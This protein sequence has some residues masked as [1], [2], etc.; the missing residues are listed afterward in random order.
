VSEKILKATEEKE[1]IIREIKV[2]RIHGIQSLRF[3]K[4]RIEKSIFRR[5]RL[6]LSLSLISAIP[7]KSFVIFITDLSTN[8]GELIT[9]IQKLRDAKALIISPNPI[10]FSELKPEREEILKLYRKYVEREEMIRKMNRIVPTIDVGPRDLLS[11]IGGSSM[12]SSV[13]SVIIA[14][15]LGL[16]AP[17][18]APVV[19]RRCLL[20][21]DLLRS[22]GLRILN[23]GT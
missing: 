10:L 12:I 4:I 22:P 14:V 1:R 9:A 21:P 18:L 8:V 5:I 13:S 15:A 11:E 6:G 17:L 20:I 23:L 3:P 16:K 19:F 2:P 7:S